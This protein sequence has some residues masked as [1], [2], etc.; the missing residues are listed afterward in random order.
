[1]AAPDFFSF[2]WLINVDRMNNLWCSIVQ[3]GCYQHRYECYG[4]IHVRTIVHN[5]DF[6]DFTAGSNFSESALSGCTCPG[7]TIMFEC[8]VSSGSGGSTVWQGTAFDCA[9]N[10]I[11]LR[12]SQFESQT[13][14]GECN[15]GAIIGRGIRSFDN[16]FT[17]QLNVSVTTNLHG[18]TVECVYDNGTTT[19]IGNSSIVITTGEK[20]HQSSL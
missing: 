9:R 17:S 2:S 15:N 20:K 19:T 16:A 10:E 18:K 6:I 13:A 7:H 4:P 1:M 14:I 11:L 5:H 12:H 8:T 3:F